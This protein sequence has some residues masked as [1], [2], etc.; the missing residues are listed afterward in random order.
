MDGYFLFTLYL[1]ELF[2]DFIND[3]LMKIA[4]RSKTYLKVGFFIIK[5]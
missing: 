3:F 1:I 2:N 4:L 5:S